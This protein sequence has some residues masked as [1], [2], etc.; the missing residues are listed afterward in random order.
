M[1]I[2]RQIGSRRAT[3]LASARARMGSVFPLGIATRL[4]I[5]LIA[6]AVLAAAANLIA[7]EGAAII[8]M[9]TLS[10]PRVTASPQTGAR[11]R[12]PSGAYSWAHDR[13]SADALTRAV[14]S[15]ERSVQARAGVNSGATDGGYQSAAAA[16]RA[17]A[18]NAGIASIERQAVQYLDRGQALIRVA[19]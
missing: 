16:L 2:E 5:P 9:S 7:R 19:D 12:V 11:S 4:S 14:D 18:R 13:Q 10:P 1:A 17:A 8:H 6:V 15:Y 3:F